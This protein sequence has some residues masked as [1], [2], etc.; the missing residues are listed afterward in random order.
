MSSLPPKDHRDLLK[1]AL[2]KIDNLQ[3]QLDKQR[4]PIA[5]IGM[6]LRFPN[7]ANDPEK[8]WQLLRAGVDCITEI[9]PSRW[10]LDDYYDPDPEA[11]GK[12]YTR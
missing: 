2:L 6:S 12:M 4:E 11:P 7:G 8:F 9:P 5:I 10:N 1:R 3:A